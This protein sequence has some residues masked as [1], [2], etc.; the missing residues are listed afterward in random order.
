VVDFE[1]WY[2]PC[3]PNKII[4]VQHQWSGNKSIAMWIYRHITP[5]EENNIE[6]DIEAITQYTKQ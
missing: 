6:R 1:H 5:L 4:L 3:S 2:H